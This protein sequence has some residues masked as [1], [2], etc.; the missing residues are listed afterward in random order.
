M[1]KVVIIL[2]PL[3]ILC[4]V[5]SCKD[6]FLESRPQDGSLTDVNVFT[7]KGDF[8][9]FLFGAYHELQYSNASGNVWITLPG[10]ISQD[11]VGVDELPKVLGSL[12]T[13]GDGS[14]AAYW[15]NLYKVV[16]RVNTVLAELAED[17]T[18]LSEEDKVQLEAEA[19]FLRGFAYF[20]IA[21]AWGSVPMPLTSYN[22]DQNSIECTPEAQV[23]DQVIQD[24]N[25]AAEN[26]PAPAGWGEEN[27]GRATKGAALAYLANAYMYKKSWAEAEGA[28]Q[29]LI[30]L[31][32]YALLPDVRD[33]FSQENENNEESIFEIQYR[34][35]DN[36]AFDWSGQPNN[37]HTLNEWTSP[38]NIGLPYA[39]FGGWGETIMNMKLAE[40][41][42]PGDE[43]RT[44]LIKTVGETYQ[45]EKMAE[46]VT[47]PE[48][49]IQS[50]SAFSTKYWLGP[51][52]NYLGG[53][54][55][56][57]MRYAEF[58]L[59]YAEI[60]FE[61]GKTGEG[62][63]QFN[64]VRNRVGL[65][66]KEVSAD[67]ETFMSDLMKER[68]AELNFEPNLWFHYTR[69]GRAASFLQDEYGITFNNAWNYLPIPQGERDQNPNLCQNDGY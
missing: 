45:G 22:P 29:E 20:M 6:S 30:E 65:P 2:L 32:S 4:V 48:S 33:V 56:P 12:L 16:G 8:E 14:I 55:L 25:Y 49:I 54:N 43:R 62:Y 28:S 66:D 38:R 19:K 57:Q 36:G 47:I 41:F 68:R 34:D 50:N 64:K 23:W 52:D 3:A 53:Q 31:N 39:P 37:G 27:L 63:Q 10:Y 42:E 46:P 9:S 21:R 59:N 60:L 24:L 7:S 1:R 15:I 51:Y 58:L 5:W 11:L 13:P 67:K 26:L 35:V 40:S 44:K 69:T 18:D 61:L 17:A